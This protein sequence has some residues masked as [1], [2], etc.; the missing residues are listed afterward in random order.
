MFTCVVSNEPLCLCDSGSACVDECA[1][2]LCSPVGYK[3]ISGTGGWSHLRFIMG[4][5][6]GGCLC[7]AYWQLGRNC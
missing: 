7:Q 4:K 6:A 1:H 5:S 2:F 3:D